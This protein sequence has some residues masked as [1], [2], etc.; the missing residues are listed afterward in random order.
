MNLR[1]DE[2]QILMCEISGIKIPNELLEFY[3]DNTVKHIKEFCGKP[4]EYKQFDTK[5]ISRPLNIKLCKKCIHS[6]ENGDCVT[7]EESPFDSFICRQ[8][9]QFELELYEE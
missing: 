2:E 4:N 8:N 5:D 1:K 9:E 3:E 7:K 6:N